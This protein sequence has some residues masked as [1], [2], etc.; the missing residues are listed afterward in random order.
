MVAFHHNISLS[1]I[2]CLDKV[3]NPLSRNEIR[4][5]FQ[6]L[7][8]IHSIFETITCT[9]TSSEQKGSKRQSH[10]HKLLKTGMRGTQSS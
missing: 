8:V 3:A 4:R 9:D 1:I 6:S 10:S 2:K 7:V 5:S